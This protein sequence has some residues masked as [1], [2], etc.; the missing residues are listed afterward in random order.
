MFLNM[1]NNKFVDKVYSDRPEKEFTVMVP[2]SKLEE[3][4]RHNAELRKLGYT[5]VLRQN[6]YEIID[7][8]FP[9]QDL[10]LQEVGIPLYD[11]LQV[12]TESG[13]LYVELSG[14]AAVYD[15]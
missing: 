13:R 3:V 9:Y 1:L 10:T 15:C 5:T 11:V 7:E 8:D 4:K 12:S 6:F 14:D 2:E